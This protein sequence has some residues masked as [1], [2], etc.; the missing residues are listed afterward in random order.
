MI[1]IGFDAKNLFTDSSGLGNYSRNSVELLTKYQPENSY[2]IFSAYDKNRVG[3]SIPKGVKIITPGGVIGDI[4]P[5]LWRNCA[6]ARD[7]RKSRIN[8]FHGLCNHLPSDIR[9]SGATSIITIHDLIFLRY[10]NLYPKFKRHYL[11]FQYKRSCNKADM[12]IAISEQTKNDLIEFWDLPPEK[13]KVV[14]Q[15]CNSIYTKRAEPEVN[16]RVRKRYNLP[17][18]YIV[19]V[20]TIEERKNLL[21][22]LHALHEGKIDTPLVACGRWTPYVDK[23]KKYIEENNMHSQV[24]FIHD[25][26][27]EEL[28]SIYQ[29]ARAS[30][31]VSLFEGFGIPILESM[32][33][34]TPVITS[35]GGV[36]KEAGGDAALYVG[37]Y[38]LEEMIETLKLILRDEQKRSEIIEAGY[39]HVKN[40]TD[41]KIAE[42]LMNIY[43]RFI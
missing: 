18:E 7:I 15:G 24:I 36:F 19:S 1:K 27:I 25:C 2:N 4:I 32:H 38:D 26:S 14:Y 16:Q 39:R 28:P 34:G 22:T 21:L 17:E 13:I 11:E 33:S 30:V 31:F 3:F 23:L 8:I 42:N 41:D 5:A 10:P 20:G 43:R 37:V 35:R 29:M 9:H 40:F 6:M 12:I